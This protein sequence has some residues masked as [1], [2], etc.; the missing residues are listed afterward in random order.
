MID[1][2]IHPLPRLG[3]KAYRGHVEALRRMTANIAPD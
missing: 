3:R 2:I 1:P